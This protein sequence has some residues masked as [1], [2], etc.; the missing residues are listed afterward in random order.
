[1]RCRKHPVAGS[2]HC[3]I[4]EMNVESYRCRSFAEEKTTRKFAKDTSGP[5]R[6][7]SCCYPGPALARETSL[8]KHFCNIPRYRSVVATPV[9]SCS[10]YKSPSGFFQKRYEQALLLYK[11]LVGIGSESAITY[12]NIG[13]GVFQGSCRIMC[14]LP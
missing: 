9:S 6:P 7:K 8:E 3:V 13:V 10:R 2:H 14:H 4:L 5:P 12:N 1:M 11:T